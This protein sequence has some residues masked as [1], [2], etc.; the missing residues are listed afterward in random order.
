L[1]SQIKCNHRP[2]QIGHTLLG[3]VDKKITSSP[4]VLFIIT[5][6]QFYVFSL[7]M[8]KKSVMQCKGYLKVKNNLSQNWEIF[9]ILSRKKH[10]FWFVRW[11]SKATTSLIYQVFIYLLWDLILQVFYT[12]ICFHVV[13]SL[14]WQQTIFSFQNNQKM[15]SKIE[16]RN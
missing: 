8:R 1:T 10:C 13:N 3:I 11:S 16:Y 5:S 2:L 14:K 9:Q 4:Q 7:K 6:K 15:W 12:K